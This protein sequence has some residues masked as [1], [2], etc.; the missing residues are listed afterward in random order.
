[1]ELGSMLLPGQ[2]QAPGSWV[3]F[4]YQSTL[5]AVY[6]FGVPWLEFPIVL[7][8]PHYPEGTYIYQLLAETESGVHLYGVGHVIL[9]SRAGISGQIT[10][11]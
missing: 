1:M 4:P 10:R 3:S 6:L 7:S 9:S 2:P 5:D 8:Y 11:I